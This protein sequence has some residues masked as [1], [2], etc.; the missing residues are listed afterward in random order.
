MKLT[1]VVDKAKGQLA[2]VTGLQPVTVVSAEKAEA[3]WNVQIEMIEVHRTPN[4]Q[5]LLGLY[6]AQ[7]DEDADLVSWARERLRVR[8]DSAAG[9]GAME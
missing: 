4:T 2:D 9:E 3:G 1:E 6:D 8:G 5:D 7:L